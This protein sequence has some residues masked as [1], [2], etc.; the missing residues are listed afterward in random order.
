MK[1]A[2]WYSLIKKLYFSCTETKHQA[3]ECLSNRL[4]VK[5]KGKFHSSICEKNDYHTVNYQYLFCNIPCTLIEIEEVKWLAVIK[6]QTK[7]MSQVILS[8]ILAKKQ[9]EPKQR[10]SKSEKVERLKIH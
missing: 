5:W 7:L 4:C 9:S 10:K 8:I 1:N 6:A 2:G 3:S